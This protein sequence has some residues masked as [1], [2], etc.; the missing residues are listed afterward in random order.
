MFEDLHGIM[1]PIASPCN[2]ADRFL[3]DAFAAHGDRL[4]EQGVQG[5]YV[6]GAT[7]DGYSMRLA[8]RKRAVEIAVELSRK[9][10]GKVITHI[11]APNTHDAIELA[12]HSAKTGVNAIS[13]M[14]PANRSHAEL[15]SYYT[16]IGRAAQLPL[17]VYHIPILTGHVLTVDEMTRL[18]DIDH[19]IGFK[20]S[21]WN[22]FFMHRVMQKRPDTIVF[23]GNDEVLLPGLL[24]G[25]IG[26]IGMNYNLFPR[27]FLAIYHAAMDKEIERGM[28]LQNRF[29]A[30]AD[31]FWRYGGIKANFETLMRETDGAPY[32]WRCPRPARNEEFD[33]K[34][35]AEVR[36]KIEDIEKAIA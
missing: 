24:F 33:R 30:Y 1:V 13:S 35:L 10:G 9:H 14:P 28:D 15:I 8:E 18:L 27:L 21:D 4:Y 26:G 20:F 12:E 7:G 3:G 19:V 6:C 2:E 16:D 17:L 25:A 22:L 29:L 5:L 11:G 34:F 31:V 23:N 36:P 32:Y